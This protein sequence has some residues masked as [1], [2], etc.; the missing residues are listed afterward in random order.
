LNAFNT[1]LSFATEMGMTIF[2]ELLDEGGVKPSL[3]EGSLRGNRDI[4]RGC[5]DN[6]RHNKLSNVTKSNID[7]NLILTDANIN[8]AKQNAFKLLNVSKCIDMPKRHEVALLTAPSPCCSIFFLLF[9]NS[10]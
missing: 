4:S 3:L 8:L 1:A 2:P 9:Y 7:T 6:I 5:K 10:R